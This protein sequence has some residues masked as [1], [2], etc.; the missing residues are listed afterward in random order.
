MPADAP[1]PFSPPTACRRAIPAASPA[2]H[3]ASLADRLPLPAEPESAPA[4]RWCQTHA[5]RARSSAPPQCSPRYNGS[6]A[7][8]HSPPSQLSPFPVGWP[9]TR[10]RLWKASPDARR[11]SEG[12]DSASPQRD[13]RVAMHKRDLLVA[14]TGEAFLLLL[15]ALAGWLA[16]Q[17]LIFA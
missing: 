13:R 14:P 5:A 4:R 7:P 6:T 1:A 3:A 10:R 17:P 9:R 11:A 16:H 2:A 8:A 15:A 12:R